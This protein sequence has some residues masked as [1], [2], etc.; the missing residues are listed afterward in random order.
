LTG[1]PHP[2]MGCT[3]PEV[4]VVPLERAELRFAPRAWPFADERRADIDAHF[5]ELRRDKP[6]MWNGRVLLLYEHAI[7]DRVLRGTCLETDFASM[8]SWHAWGWP[9]FSMRSCFGQAA[10]RA[11]DGAFVLGVMAS[12]TANAGKVYFPSGTP[13]PRDVVGGRVDLAGSVLREL[14]EETGL[15]AADVTPEPGWYAALT[16]ARIAMYKP[17]RARFSADE[18]RARILAHIAAEAQPELAGVRIVRGPDD[19]D[20]MMPNF[21]AAFLKHMWNGTSA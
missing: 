15:T 20:P 14:N 5:A 7:A 8:L 16:G 11:A 17:M 1:L 18:L 4:T 6:E 19:L 9:D 13:D 3:M 2:G 12:H 10:L 21:V